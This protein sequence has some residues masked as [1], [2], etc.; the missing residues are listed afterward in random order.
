MGVERVALGL[1]GQPTVPEMMAMARSAEALG[2]ESVWLTE[3]R[4]TRDAVTTAAAVATATERVKI[5]TAVVNPF[6]RGAVLMAVT[7]ATLDELAGGRM[8]LGIGPGSPHILDKQGFAFGRPLTR[9]REH[10]EVIQHLLTGERVTYEGSTVTVRDVQLDFA[11]RRPRIPIYLGVTGPKALEL[12]GEIA[13]GVMLNGWVSTAYTR[14]AI[15]RVRAGATR[16]GRDAADVDVSA[17]LAVSLDRDSAT[18]LNAVRPLVGT[19][20]ANFPNIAQESGLPE[21]TLEAVRAAHARGGRAA[22]AEEVADEV[23]RE[24]ACAGTPD[25]CRALLKQ[26]RE[27][28]VALPI[29]GLVH[30]DAETALR[31][32][33]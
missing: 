23:V 21:E 24:L 29:L 33:G 11:P 1:L 9:M 22:A 10:I 30:G 32:L 3:T 26:R 4:F 20:L 27:A 28:G 6:T 17:F 8:I 19:Y 13:D 18:A 15:E 7:L 12:A 2:Y 31:E 14:R 5:G 25:E 16:A